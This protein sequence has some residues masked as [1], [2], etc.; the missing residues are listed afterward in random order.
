MILV[1]TCVWSLALRRKGPLRPPQG[2]AL[3][4][5]KL[6]EA[7]EPVTLPGIVLQEVLSG[8]RDEEQHA[9]LLARLAPFP[10]LIATRIDHL[11]AA[12]I[13]NTCRRRGISLTAVDC[14]IAAQAIENDAR[15]MTTD[16]DFVRVQAHC[17]LK[18]LS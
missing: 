10:V 12:D 11:H 14:L 17:D 5:L 18:L 1:D 13:A 9:R 16:D 7:E 2:A 6:V 8:V 15:L 3:E 4:L